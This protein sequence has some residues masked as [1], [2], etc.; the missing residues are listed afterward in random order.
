MSKSDFK[1]LWNELGF[2]S[3]G[4]FVYGFL[5]NSYVLFA[6]ANGAKMLWF[7]FPVE[8]DENDKQNIQSWEKKDYAKKV[9]FTGDGTMDVEMTFRETILPTKEDIIKEVIMGVT[10]YIADKYPEA[11]INCSGTDC[12]CDNNLEVYEVNGLPIPMCAECAKKL[13]ENIDEAYEEMERQ[14]GNY[15]RGFLGASLFSIPGILVT[16]LL[17]MLGKI[18]A[19]SGIVYYF[20][21]QKGYIWFKG[22]FDKLGVAIVSLTSLLFVV[23]GTY[24]SYIASI[25]VELCKG[26]SS[27]E[28]LS[29]SEAT[30]FAFVYVKA[31]EVEEEL[32][33]NIYMSLFICGIIIVIYAYG[34]F[35]STGKPTVKKL[36]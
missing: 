27:S 30:K 25:V 18:A 2:K 26:D 20:L 5:K 7:R 19:L 31:P 6:Q 33:S 17:F 1:E 35:K 23:I 16:F 12:S 10:G 15:L 29:V 11:R 13:G 9:E 8:L 32:L 4:S 24:L 14:P 22:K 36:S 3:A 21:A 28:G 34:A